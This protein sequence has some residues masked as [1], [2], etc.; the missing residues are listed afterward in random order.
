MTITRG[1][2]EARHHVQ[3]DFVLQSERLYL[4]PSWIE[5]T[6][7]E[8]QDLE[9]L[10][11][12]LGAR[13]PESW[14]P[15][16]V[17]DAGSADGWW[18]WYIIASQGEEALLAGVAGVRGWPGVDGTIQFGCSFIP[19]FQTKGYGT[20]AV[21]LLT[22]WLLV[23]PGIRRVTANTPRDNQKAIAFLQTLGF[24]KLPT[25]DGEFFRFEK[26]KT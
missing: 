12:V 7:A 10:S 16:V 25:E 3:S 20:E 2:L 11:A 5:S 23:Q 4:K 14:P 8:T 22:D 9:H 19:E 15:E 24:S 26:V 6:K 1:F 17:A 13:V 18:D 21:R